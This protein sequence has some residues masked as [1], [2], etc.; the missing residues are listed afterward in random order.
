[1]KNFVSF[2]AKYYKH[3]NAKGEIGH[4]ERLFEDNKN[5]IKAFA[6]DNF[7]CGYSIIDKYQEVYDRVEAAKG[8][9]LQK[10]A[11]TFIDGVLSFSA[12]SFEELKKDPEYKKKMGEYIDK[13]MEEVKNQTGLTPLGWVFHADEGYRDE[14]SSDMENKDV[15]KM[16]YHAQ[17]IFFNHDFDK[18]IAPLRFMCSRGNKSP[19]SGL[20]DLAGTVFEP[21]GFVRGNQKE[22]KKADHLE[23]DEWI[24]KR[25]ADLEDQIEKNQ[26]LVDK[27]GNMVVKVRKTCDTLNSSINHIKQQEEQF[28]ELKPMVQQAADRIA[29]AYNEKNSSFRKYADILEKNS[30]KAFEAFKKL[31]TKLIEF[32]KGALPDFKNTNDVMHE[33]D[34]NLKNIQDMMEEVQQQKISTKNTNRNI[35]KP[36]PF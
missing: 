31:G 24:A 11:N 5:Q 6:K 4:V 1:M 8:K 25:Q 27:I 14:L 36:K 34:L 22:Q 23:K 15:Y 16:N 10:N 21:L 17:L 9:K 32:F 3:S 33:L 30:P 29:T 19:W 7:N 28:K 12:E 20:Q 13:Y 18:G 26:E 2:N 35:R